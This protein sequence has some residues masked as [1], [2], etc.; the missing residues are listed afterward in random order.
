MAQDFSSELANLIAQQQQFIQG[1]A[2]GDMPGGD[3]NWGSQFE[4]LLNQMM[5]SGGMIDVSGAGQAAQMDADKFWRDRSADINQR[6][7]AGG[8]TG[9][10]AQSNALSQ[11]LSDISQGVGAETLRAKTGA[12]EQAEGRK[13]GALQAMMQKVAG[14]QAERGLN[15]QEYGQRRD[16]FGK[17]AGA[18]QA[19]IDALLK[20]S[21][22]SGGSIGAKS[23]SLGNGLPL[24]QA[25]GGG[26][27]DFSQ[28][29]SFLQSLKPTKPTGS[30]QSK[31]AGENFA[32]A[33]TPYGSQL[34][35]QRQAANS[36][37]G[38]NREQYGKENLAFMQLIGPL[39]AQLLGQ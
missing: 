37:L 28:I 15:L 12:M 5:Q 34:D 7:V 30:F 22:L 13:M 2:P 26:G 6:M 1:L 25:G 32:F 19:L 3:V 27:Q 33:G 24:Q 9:S 21:A 8:G 38:F 39:L 17:Q 31:D 10:S 23:M 36:M 14:N 16:V 35:Q 4:Q 18:G 29:V 11:A 20:Q